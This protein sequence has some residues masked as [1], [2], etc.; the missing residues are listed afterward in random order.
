M[1]QNPTH[2]FSLEGQVRASAAEHA[3]QRRVGVLVLQST[4]HAFS[5]EG[6][7]RASAA[8]HA[9]QRRVGVLVL[10]SMLCSRGTLGVTISR[11]VR[12]DEN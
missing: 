3:F 9:L 7:V 2:A 12:V 5:L 10:Q 6:Q 4:T 11:E 1:L 8:E